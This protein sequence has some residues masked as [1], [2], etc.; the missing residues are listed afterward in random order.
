MGRW[1]DE[2]HVAHF[3]LLF[4]VSPFS[5]PSSC[6]IAPICNAS[7]SKSPQLSTALPGRQPCSSSGS[8]FCL[9]LSS[10]RGSSAAKL[11]CPTTEGGPAVLGHRSAAGQGLCGAWSSRLYSNAA[12][13][14]CH[15]KF[16]CAQCILLSL[17]IAQP[18]VRG[19]VKALLI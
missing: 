18:Q 16:T 8:V 19:Y 12:L 7:Y 9:R 10:D 1:S 6:L 4:S 17:D 13:L 14:H 11:A 5:A 15:L 3:E 2:K